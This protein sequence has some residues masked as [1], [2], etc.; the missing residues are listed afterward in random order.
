MNSMS[1]ARMALDHRPGPTS[2]TSETDSFVLGMA[3]SLVKLSRR[4]LV[5]HKCPS[6]P[7]GRRCDPLL[8]PFQQTGEAEVLS[9]SGEIVHGA[10]MPILPR[11]SQP[12]APSQFLLAENSRSS[13]CSTQQP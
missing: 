10:P 11:L 1:P 9:G 7:I 6:C 2:A 5:Y 13:S 4:P 8:D 12:D 3:F